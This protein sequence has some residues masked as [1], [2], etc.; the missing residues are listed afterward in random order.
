MEWLWTDRLPLGKLTLLVGDPSAGKSYLSLA[1]AAAIT[2][3][4]PL[5]AGEEPAAPGS[6]VIYNS[7]DGPEDTLRPRADLCE[8][9]PAR[10]VLLDAFTVDG[11]RAG[12]TAGHIPALDRLLDAIENPRALVVDP[13]ASIVGSG[14]DVY[15]DNEVRAALDPLVELARRRSIAVLGI[16]HMNKATALKALYR[17]SVRLTRL[18][19]AVLHAGRHRHAG[20]LSL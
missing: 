20:T 5:P 13:V 14:V 16:A 9:D 17:V 15:R 10:A 18:R 12:F 7:E 6:V 19:R 11:S 4:A 1:V 2:R 8:V 3:D